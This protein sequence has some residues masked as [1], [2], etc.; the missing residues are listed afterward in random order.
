MFTYLLF[1]WINDNRTYRCRCN[2]GLRKIL[3]KASVMQEARDQRYA[4]ECTALG[5]VCSCLLEALCVRNH[6][7]ILKVAAFWSTWTT[8]VYPH[9]NTGFRSEHLWWHIWGSF[10]IVSWLTLWLSKVELPIQ[11][12]LKIWT[13]NSLDT[14]KMLLSVG[15]EENS[16]TAKPMNNCSLFRR[17]VHGEEDKTDFEV[18]F[19]TTL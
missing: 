15:T 14:A 5:Q 9:T 19:C 10:S 2:V 16:S 4:S 18:D 11:F 7:D 6:R 17:F 1:R 12:C 3:R 13:R 8:S